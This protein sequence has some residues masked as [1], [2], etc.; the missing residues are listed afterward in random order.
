MMCQERSIIKYIALRASFVRRIEESAEK[1]KEYYRAVFLS[2]RIKL[3][4]EWPNMTQIGM[5]LAHIVHEA[6]VIVSA[7][8]SRDAL[9]NDNDECQEALWD[10][11]LVA[12][13]AESSEG[14]QAPFK[15][16]FGTLA[17]HPIFQ[18]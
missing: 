9:Q 5:K 2:Q 3:G 13:P 11:N 4:S 15:G 16:C 7:R 8:R 12:A 6:R 10:N 18:E 17:P 14:P 1:N